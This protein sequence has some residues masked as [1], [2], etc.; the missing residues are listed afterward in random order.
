MQPKGRGG[1]NG[2]QSDPHEQPMTTTVA[3]TVDVRE[4]L[5]AQAIMVAWK[6]IRP[7]PAG[8]VLEIVC[9]A[10]DVKEDLLIWAKELGHVVSAIDARA[11]D[12]WL[13]VQKSHR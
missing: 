13:W 3:A 6:A 7:M 5:C 9:N 10:E 12:T 1:Y 4:M 8:S 11:G 2:C